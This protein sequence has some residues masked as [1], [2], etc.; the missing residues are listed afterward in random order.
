MCWLLF[1]GTYLLYLA[2]VV[3]FEPTND[4]IKIRCVT[5]SPY[6]IIKEHINH[7][8]LLILYS[9]IPSVYC[10]FLWNTLI[11]I[12]I[13]TAIIA[14]KR[15]KSMNCIC[16][17]FRNRYRRTA[18]WA[19]FNF[20]IVCLLHKNRFWGE[21]LHLTYSPQQ[22]STGTPWQKSF[23]FPFAYSYSLIASTYSATQNHYIKIG[24]SPFSF[25]PQTASF[26][27]AVTRRIADRHRYGYPQIPKGIIYI[28]IG[29]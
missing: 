11:L 3:G 22:S 16:L 8:P 24:L 14:I 10:F 7:A 21:D 9:L 20:H 2:T 29:V 6:R 19:I 26:H 23:V 18:K 15:V 13:H 1:R 27:Q 25:S 17:L 28:K 5:T 12:A 4:G